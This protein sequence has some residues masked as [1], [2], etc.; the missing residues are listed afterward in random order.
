MGN[1]V[2]V[3]GGEACYFNNYRAAVGYAAS[4]GLCAHNVRVC[5]EKNLY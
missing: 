4:Y 1:F 5:L 3:I 2:V